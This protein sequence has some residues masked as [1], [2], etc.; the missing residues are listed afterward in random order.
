M[1]KTLAGGDCL[2]SAEGGFPGESPLLRVE[3]AV[4][5]IDSGF[6][7]YM[8]VGTSLKVASDLDFDGRGEPPL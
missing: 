7:N 5:C 2:S 6:Q 8:A 3:V 1:C 4:Q